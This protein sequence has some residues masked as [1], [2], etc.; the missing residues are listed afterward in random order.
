MTPRRTPPEDTLQG[1]LLAVFWGESS[2]D[3]LED[4]PGCPPGCRSG[5]PPG[6]VLL[7]CRLG[8]FLQGVL[9]GFLQGVLLREIRPLPPRYFSTLISPIPRLQ[10]RGVHEVL[11]YFVESYTEKILIGKKTGKKY[12]CA[13]TGKFF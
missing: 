7:V 11:L 1:G 10:F 13:T 9:R 5:C 6:G 2:R 8:G 12:P 4:T 3:T